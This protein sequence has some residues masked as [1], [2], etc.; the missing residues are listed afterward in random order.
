MGDAPRLPAALEQRP[1][2]IPAWAPG[3]GRVVLVTSL[4]LASGVAC[5]ICTFTVENTLLAVAL[6]GFALLLF[7]LTALFPHDVRRR[8]ELIANGKG[9][10]ALVTEVRGRAVSY[11]FEV[12]GVL[13]EGTDPIDLR[14]P[15]FH[16]PPKEGDFIFI[17]YDEEDRRR[18]IIF[19]LAH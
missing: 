11:T 4:F 10:A 16:I 17:V 18:S 15:R 5:A 1:R 3:I 7:L 12:A 13:R 6:G 8:R 19:D 9:T 14:D 2:P